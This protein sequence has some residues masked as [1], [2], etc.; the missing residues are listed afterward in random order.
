MSRL[1]LIAVSIFLSFPAFA[2][3]R[4]NSP[5]TRVELILSTARPD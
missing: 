3:E 5:R 4:L 1:A 2:D